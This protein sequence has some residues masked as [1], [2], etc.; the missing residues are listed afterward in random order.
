[1]SAKSLVKAMVVSSLLSQGNGASRAS[2]QRRY[3]GIK[4]EH[5]STMSASLAKANNS[6]KKGDPIT[7]LGTLRNNFYPS[8]HSGPRTHKKGVRIEDKKMYKEMLK[9]AQSIT[10]DAKMERAVKKL[11]KLINM[12]YGDSKK[13]KTLRKRISR[14]F[15]YNL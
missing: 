11:I 5:N 7:A 10:K 4:N 14:K 3:N 13:A 8:Y 9:K 6:L 12:G 15:G 1:M 2:S